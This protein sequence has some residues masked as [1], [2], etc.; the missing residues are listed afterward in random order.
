MTAIR[1]DHAV[2]IR[3]GKAEQAA[4][5][6]VIP[7]AFDREIEPQEAKHGDE[8]AQE[9]RDRVAD[10][11]LIAAGAAAPALEQ[12]AENGNE[13]NRGENVPAFGAAAPPAEEGFLVGDAP[14]GA[15]QKRTHDRAED[16]RENN[17][18]NRKRPVIEDRHET[19]LA[20]IT[21]AAA[22]RRSRR[23]DCNQ[24]TAHE[25]APELRTDREEGIVI[26]TH[27]YTN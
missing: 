5:E 6:Y 15:V 10:R 8:G 24:R 11:D 16:R 21:A 12:P 27:T 13:L 19:A 4:E 26:P 7:Q 14:C 3:E 9:L 1:N 20:L 2:D 18:V 25:G 23:L 22:A 17:E